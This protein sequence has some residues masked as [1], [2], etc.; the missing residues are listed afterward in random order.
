MKLRI[1]D[2][3]DDYVDDALPL[4]PLPQPEIPMEKPQRKQMP[5]RPRG[6]KYVQMAAA[7]VLVVSL[8]AVVWLS[9]GERSSGGASLTDVDMGE[10]AM[11][12]PME[13]SPEPVQ[14]DIKAE[15][16]QEDGYFLTGFATEDQGLTVMADQIVR[17]GLRF[18]VTLT[19]EA[20]LQQVTGFTMD[21][22]EPY[23]ML[24]DGTMVGPTEAGSQTDPENPFSVQDVYDFTG[25][26]EESQLDGAVLYLVIQQVTIDTDSGSK[27]F[28]GDWSIMATGDEVALADQLPD[29]ILE[30]EPADTLRPDQDYFLSDVR[31]S[32]KECSFWLHTR[33]DQYALAPLGQLDMAAEELTDATCYGFAIETADGTNL[34]EVTLETALMQTK[35]VTDTQNLVKCTVTWAQEIDPAQV[36]GVYFTDGTTSV[37][38]SIDAYEY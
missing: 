6:K 19:V 20:D 38:A 26:V 37:T 27:T 11:E 32:A 9:L 5:R 7:V 12:E 33:A 17:S 28:R 4:D 23:L 1:T 8:S 24:S 29:G 18:T 16:L 30:T 2:L 36:T 22:A 10:E 15:S 21:D 25:A 31:V 13:P 14:E 3:L 35:G 34:G